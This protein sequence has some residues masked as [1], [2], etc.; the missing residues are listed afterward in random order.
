GEAGDGRAAGAADLAGNDLL[1][2]LVAQIRVGDRSRRVVEIRADVEA[3]SLIPRLL[4]E[5]LVAGPAEVL[6]DRVARVA[7]AVDLFPRVPA[8]VT[9]PELARSG[10]RRDAE[11]VAQAVRDD[12]ARGRVRGDQRVVEHGRAGRGIDAQDRAAEADAVAR[13]TDVLRA[14][15]AA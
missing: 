1:A 3:G 11:R 6:D 10:T 13:R 15:R 4:R 7:D 8:D 14:Q 2:V 12:A 9:D 5:A